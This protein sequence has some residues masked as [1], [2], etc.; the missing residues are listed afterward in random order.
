VGSSD[1]TTRSE[2]YGAGRPIR[3]VRAEFDSKTLLGKVW[4]MVAEV[5]PQYASFYGYQLFLGTAY[6][7]VLS[8]GIPAWWLLLCGFVRAAP[9]ALAFLLE[10]FLPLVGLLIFTGFH[11]NV[12]MPQNL[13]RSGV[14]MVLSFAISH[15]ATCLCTEIV[16][17]SIL[18]QDPAVGPFNA[19]PVASEARQGLPYI[20]HLV[21]P[22]LQYVE[23]LNTTLP[24]EDA[25]GCT[26]LG[27]SNVF[28]VAGW[29]QR[30]VSLNMRP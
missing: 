23:H 12:G 11:L 30:T 21:L 28:A 2:A 6:F 19:L 24:G 8:L 7:L 1:Q 18:M 25:Q 26:S 4:S 5:L 9:V 27:L 16:P 20:K 13:H 22:V 14:L 10:V 3:E 17:A 15:S 29:T